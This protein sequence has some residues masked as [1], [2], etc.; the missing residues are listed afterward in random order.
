MRT[1]NN[2]RPVECIGQG[3]SLPWECPYKGQ[4]LIEGLLFFYRPDDSDSAVSRVAV[5]WKFPSRPKSLGLDIRC[6]ASDLHI[7]VEELFEMNSK[8]SLKL[9]SSGKIDVSGARGR[10]LRLIFRAGER[11]AP[12]LVQI[13]P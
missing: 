13:L 10:V 1:R 11:E 12:V 8:T 5:E 2:K 3:K 4:W 6:V 7:G 9:L